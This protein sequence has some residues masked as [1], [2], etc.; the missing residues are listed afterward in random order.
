MV[1]HISQCS[2]LVGCINGKGR[3]LKQLI[4]WSCMECVHDLDAD[5]VITLLHKCTGYLS[6]T[7]HG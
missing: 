2:I 5:W 3:L 7:V 4:D 1:I 6:V